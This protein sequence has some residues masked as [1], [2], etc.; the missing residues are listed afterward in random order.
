MPPRVK[1]FGSR[2]L[3]RINADEDFELQDWSEKF[4]VSK[5][6]LR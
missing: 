3:L 1:G 4:G 5:E 2:P 6:R